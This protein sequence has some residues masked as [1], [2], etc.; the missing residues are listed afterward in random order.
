MTSNHVFI[1]ANIL[2][3]KSNTPLGV[4]LLPVFTP[5]HD[6]CNYCSF[7]FRCVLFR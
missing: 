4:I 3:K 5:L 2:L 7:G 6:G 1:E